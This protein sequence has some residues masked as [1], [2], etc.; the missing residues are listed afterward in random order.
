MKQHKQYEL[1]WTQPPALTPLMEN[2]FNFYDLT[3][4]IREDFRNLVKRIDFDD[5]DS[6]DGQ[7]TT[8]IDENDAS[9]KTIDK[10]VQEWLPNLRL[11][12]VDATFYYYLSNLHIEPHVQDADINVI[13]VT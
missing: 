2:G 11:Q 7:L 5:I 9:L 3:T 1:M 4:N 8:K 12:R 10:S 6:V 13:T